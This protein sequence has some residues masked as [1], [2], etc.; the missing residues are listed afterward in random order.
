MRRQCLGTSNTEEFNI[1]TSKLY[2]TKRELWKGT[3][4]S[5]PV[6]MDPLS[7]SDPTTLFAKSSRRKRLGRA[8][9]HHSGLDRLKA[10]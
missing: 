8:G 2:W 1:V 7:H 6:V 5:T 4:P 3:A 9:L 10:E